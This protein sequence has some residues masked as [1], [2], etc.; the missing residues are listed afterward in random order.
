MYAR[1]Q[2]KQKQNKPFVAT[3]GANKGK[4]HSYPN[5]KLKSENCTPKCGMQAETSNQCENGTAMLLLGSGG[6]SASIST[7]D[8]SKHFLVSLHCH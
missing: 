1:W 8:T 6:I 2:K 3:N 7:P 4:Q 5:T